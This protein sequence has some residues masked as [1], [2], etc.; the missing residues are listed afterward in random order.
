MNKS[1]QAFVLLAAANLAALSVCPGAEAPTYATLYQFTG[2]LGGPDGSYPITPVVIG[3]GG[4]LY[5]TTRY[6]GIVNATCPQGCGTAFSL[7][8]PASAGTP[9]SETILHSFT[10]ESDG[11]WPSAALTLGVDGVLYGTAGGGGASGFGVVFSLVPPSESGGLWTEHILHNFVGPV[12]PGLDGV[13]PYASLLLSE[14]GV[15]YGTAQLGGAYGGGEAFS[16]MPSPSGDWTE[17]ILYNFGGEGDGSDL[18]SSFVARGG[19]LYGTTAGG[20]AFGYG[21]AYSLSPP[22]AAG[23]AWTEAVLYSFAGG[24]DGEDPNFGNLVAGAGGVLYGTTLSG[25]AYG[26]GTVFSLTPPASQGAV[27]TESVL[28]SFFYRTGESPYGGLAI[29]KAGSLYGTTSFGGDAT[30]GLGT[31]FQL[32]PPAAP[33]RSPTCIPSRTLTE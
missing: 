8:P 21:T 25:G 23:G 13:S 14:G 9:W 17:T 30:K 22:S 20:G 1:V 33:G 31:V 28:F 7:T 19:V 2:Y 29:D 12:G 32:A 16:L 5:G 24:S 15:L 27:W 18:A 6:G 4:V 10:A 3:P 26:E 11:Y